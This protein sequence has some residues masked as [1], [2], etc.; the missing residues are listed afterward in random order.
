LPEVFGA[1]E[2]SVVEVPIT[3]FVRTL[4]SGPG[5]GG[6][7][8]VDPPST[9]ALTSATEPFSLS[10]ASFFGPAEPGEPVLKLILTVGTPQ[11]LP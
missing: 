2:G 4:L 10:F 8:G 9:L 1:L 6:V 3:A 7:A 11:E 5:A